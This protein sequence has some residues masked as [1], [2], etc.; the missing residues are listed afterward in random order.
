MERGDMICQKVVDYMQT[1]KQSVAALLRAVVSAC[2]SLVAKV[3]QRLE[4]FVKQLKRLV[5]KTDG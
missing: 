3:R 5:R 1:F 4:R 2:E